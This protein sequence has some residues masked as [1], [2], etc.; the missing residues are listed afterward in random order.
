MKSIERQIRMFI[1]LISYNYDI[2]TNVVFDRLEAKIDNTLEVFYYIEISGE[3]YS[4]SI[5]L[6]ENIETDDYI[7][8]NHIY[9]YITEHINHLIIE[10]HKDK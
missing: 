4:G 8:F 9:K 6:Y 1:E 3:T 7:D 5:V 2:F 10:S